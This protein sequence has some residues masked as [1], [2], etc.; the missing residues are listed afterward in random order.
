MIISYNKNKGFTVIE[1]LVTIFVIL[2][3]I[4]TAFLAIQ[5][6]LTRSKYLKDRFVAYYLAKEGAELVRNQRDNNWIEGENWND[7][8][9]EGFSS[10]PLG[11]TVFDRTISIEYSGHVE[12]TVEVSWGEDHKISVVSHLYN[13]WED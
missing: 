4:L 3:G 1:L 9:L 12:I 2:T 13:W 10:H 6:P 8:T 5:D 7:F 11:G